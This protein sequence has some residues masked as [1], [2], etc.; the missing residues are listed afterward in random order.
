MCSIRTNMVVLFGMFALSCNGLTMDVGDIMIVGYRSDSP[1]GLSFVTWVDLPAG[2]ELHFTD[3]GWKADNTFRDGED[4]VTWTAPAEGLDAGAVVVM[5]FGAGSADVGSFT[6]S[7]GLSGGGDQILVF[8]N[9]PADPFFLF[10]LTYDGPAWQD[11]ATGN[12]SSAL[13]DALTNAFGNIAFEH[14]DN[15]VYSG[16]QSGFRSAL[17]QAATEPTE[18][19]FDNNGVLSLSSDDFV[20]I[21]EISGAPVLEIMPPGLC[22]T[23]TV[24]LA[25]SF[26]VVSREGDGDFFTL[27]ASGVPSD[28]LYGPNPRSGYHALTNSFSWVPESTG[29]YEVVFSAYDADGTNALTICLN[30]EYPRSPG[31]LIINEYNGVSKNRFLGSDNQDG[32]NYDLDPETGEPEMG[33]PGYDTFFGRIEGN[34]RNWIEL[35]VVSNH[36][37]IRGWQIAWAEAAELPFEVNG[38]EER[39]HAPLWVPPTYVDAYWNGTGWE[40]GYWEPGYW[41]PGRWEV[42]E[43]YERNWYE[44]G[45]DPWYGAR[46][47]VDGTSIKQGILTFSDHPFWA[48]VKAGTIITIAERATIVDTNGVPILQ[49]TDT[50]FDP[51]AGDWWIH[52]STRDESGSDAAL[53]TCQHNMREEDSCAFSTGHHDWQGLVLDPYGQVVFGPVG[54]R[55]PGWDD[56][57]ADPNL[58][59]TEVGMLETDPDGSVRVLDFDDKKYASFGGPNMV[60]DDPVEYQN[61]SG[62]RS[63]FDSGDEEIAEDS[64]QDGLPD[65]WEI[66]RHHSRRMQPFLDDD[67]DGLDNMTEYIAGTNPQ[68]DDGQL[69]N[70][71][72][73]GMGNSGPS[74]K[75][76]RAGGI[77]FW[78]ISGRTYAV[79]SATTITGRWEHIASGIRGATQ[80]ETVPVSSDAPQRLYRLKITVNG[81]Q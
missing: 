78:G 14:S 1:D 17:Q 60:S 56:G 48:D 55:I 23:G 27:A 11:D 45:S 73:S 36:L 29:L 24:G 8:T 77:S 44:D 65:L 21:P 37:D 72:L 38:Y 5:N 75:G 13:P 49:G 25:F 12:A 66:D 28:A 64:D 57:K 46:Y 18:W 43:T 31:A 34:G 62:L 61:F 33:E 16:A 76:L 32:T 35:V 71:Y 63:W 22:R 30:V 80:W 50:S 41:E 2:T 42:V 47:G 74:Y 52:V 3:K 54:E 26:D 70:V 15:G 10:G 69:C 51:A 19:L 68:L 40:P 59:S 4:V 58:S 67:Q 81:N 39:W 53:I 6:G 20:V 7:L 79:E 9:T